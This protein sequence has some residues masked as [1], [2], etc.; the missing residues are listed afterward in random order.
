M[1]ILGPSWQTKIAG[2][3]GLIAGIG[4][5]AGLLLHNNYNFNSPEWLAVIAAITAGLGNMAS[6]QNNVTSEQ[7]KTKK[8]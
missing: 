5:A 4:A 8:P 3:L 6:R 2:L 1:N 7:L